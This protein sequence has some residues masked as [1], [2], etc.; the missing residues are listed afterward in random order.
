MYIQL[1]C[2]GVNNVYDWRENGTDFGFRNGANKPLG[3]CMMGRNTEFNS[4]QQTVKLHDMEM[5][6]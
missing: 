5:W 2:C 6:L 1:K 3:C 4:T